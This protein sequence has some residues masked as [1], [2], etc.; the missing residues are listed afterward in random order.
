MKAVDEIPFLRVEYFFIIFPWFVLS[1]GIETIISSHTIDQ[2]YCLLR[3]S[4]EDIY[5]VLSQSVSQSVSAW[6]SGV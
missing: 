6:L 3:V 5:K 2:T 4:A 1:G